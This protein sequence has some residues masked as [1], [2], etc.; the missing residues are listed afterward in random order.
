MSALVPLDTLAH[1]IVASFDK[2]RQYASNADDFRLRAGLQL[3]EARQRVERGEAGPGVLWTHW[4][5]AN[6][7]RTERDIQKVMKL[8]GAGDPHAALERDRA[9]ARISM[10]ATRARR[11]AAM[12]PSNVGRILQKPPVDYGALG[13]WVEQRYPLIV[14]EWRAS[15]SCGN[16]ATRAAAA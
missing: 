6:I 13:R 15:G 1:E 11:G 2:A 16:P 8:A 14:Q 9:A 10:A 5:V 12:D 3:I 4:C 7:N